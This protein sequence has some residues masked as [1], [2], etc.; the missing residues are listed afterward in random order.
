MEVREHLART[1]VLARLIIVGCGLWAGGHPVAGQTIVTTATNPAAGPTFQSVPTAVSGTY[2]AGESLRIGTRHIRLLRSRQKVAVI[3]TGTAGIQAA[4]VAEQVETP[5]R[6]YRLERYLSKAAVTVYQTR[7]FTSLDEQTQSLRQL[8]EQ[9]AADEVVPVYIHEDSGLEMI[10]TGKIVVKLRTAD[11]LT[12]LAGVQRRLGTRVEGRI[13]GTTD[14]YILAA[15]HTTARELFDLCAILE[16]EP[17]IEWAEPDFVGQTVKQS[18]R[19]NDPLFDP[20]QWYLKDIN[21]PQA[22]DIT[23]GSS[24]IIIAIL[25]DGMDLKHE[26]LKG[27]LPSNT[28]EIPNNGIDDDGNGWKDDANGW[29]FHDDNNDPSPGY[30]LDNHGTQVAGLAAATGNNGKGIAGC[31]FGCKLMPL[32]VL[33]GDPREEKEDVLNHIIAEA[34]YYAAG[35]A[36]N[37]RDRWRGADVISISLGFSE[38]N[39]VNTALQFAVQRGRNGKGCPTF[40]ASGNDGS[41][42]V[43]HRIYGVPAGTHHFR[44]ELAR[45]GSGSDGSNTVWIDSLVWP[46]AAVELFQDSDLPADWKTGGEAKWATVQNDDQG[47]HAMTGWVG[48]DSRSIRPGPLQ[49]WGRSFLDIPQKVAKGYLDF[50]VWSSLQESYPSLVGDSSFTIQDFW[51]FCVL[52]TP[53]NRRTQFICLRDELGWD[54][55]T[56][57]PVR[58]LKFMELQVVETP[59]QRFDE[60][61][62]RLKQIEAGRDRYYAA[63]WDEAGWTTVFH[64]TNVP[65]TLGTGL[66]LPDGRQTHLVRFDFTS[67]FT[68]DPNYNLAVDICMTQSHTGVWGGLCLTS[69]TDETRTIIGEEFSAL[70][71]DSPVRWRGSQGKAQLS[72]WIPLAWFGSGDEMRLFIDGVLTTKT[73]G[74]AQPKTGIAYPASNQYTTAVGASTDFGLRSD[75]SQFGAGLDFLAP[76]SGGRKA[77]CSTD[78]MGAKGDDPNNYSDSFG[79][80]SAATPLASGVAALMLSRNPSLTADRIRTILRQ[81]CQ[82]IGEEPYTSG[83][84]DYY[85]YGRIDAQ[86][87]VA[88]A[89]TGK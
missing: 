61:T 73:S 76:S 21:V 34:L 42:W 7:K 12:R 20:N 74:V 88:A 40:C 82:K 14:Q 1:S 49:D 25:D 26:D 19:P 39:L 50:W 44:W 23:T 27:A 35:Q 70:G 65:L 59:P 57:L 48:R 31:A 13:R 77:I 18:F 89:G 30:L 69:L 83:R 52:G 45:D 51:P 60:M 62:I 6:L 66:A 75:Y 78:R 41:G 86:A 56:P 22:W 68:Y 85:G 80:T 38:T 3:R 55:L 5:D 63:E 15:P 81:T 24:Q 32:K 10:P 11:D 53:Q 37:G 58:K 9:T 16:R 87:A 2:D 36:E 17:Q 67:G 28:G 8:Q 72:D 71:P 33:R 79:G 54:R 47:N 4:S 29:N 46:G 84:N 43:Q 64:G